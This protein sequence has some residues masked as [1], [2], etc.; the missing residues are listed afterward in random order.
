MLS[1]ICSMFIQN[2]AIS[3]LFENVLITM[4]THVTIATSSMI[5]WFMIF[6]FVLDFVVSL[7]KSLAKNRRVITV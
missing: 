2:L 6:C 4:F 5:T 1:A 3:A 7:M